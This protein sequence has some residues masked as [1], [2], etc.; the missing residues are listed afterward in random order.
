M[1]CHLSE[2]VPIIEPSHYSAFQGKSTLKV[3]ERRIR[4]IVELLRSRKNNADSV[5]GHGI[6]NK[7]FTIAMILEGDPVN[8]SVVDQAKAYDR[9][10]RGILWQVA[11]A[12]STE[13]C[14]M[15]CVT[16]YTN[17]YCTHTV[18]TNYQ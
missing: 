4:P 17:C 6:T 13:H 3:L 1:A 10:P 2:G 11:S 14:I 7:F 15:I 12:V 8:I 5:F 9:V 18:V 16:S